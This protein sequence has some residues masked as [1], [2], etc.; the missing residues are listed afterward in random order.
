[1]ALH[2]LRNIVKHS[3]K[4]KNEYS[5]KKIIINSVHGSYLEAI[6]KEG[7]LAKALQ[8]RGHNIKIL[9]CGGSMNACTVLF[10][11]DVPPNKW[12]CRNCCY[13]SKIFFEIIDLPYATY[14]DYLSDKDI[15][16]IKNIVKQMSIE[17]YQKY[18]HKG[19][20]VGDHALKSVQR[21]FKGE[22]SKNGRYK[23][24]DI[25][26]IRLE[27]AIIATEVAEKIIKREEPDILVTSH[28][29]YSEFGSFSDYFSNNGKRVCIWGSGDKRDTLTFDLY[30]S[31]E[32]F[33]KIYEKIRKKSILNGHEE[34]KNFFN[35]RVKAKEG[36]VSLYGFSEVKKE[37]L[38]Q[39]FN[40]DNYDKTYI[41]FPNVPW[42]AGVMDA[43]TAFENVY[44]WLT[45]TIE[46]FQD[47]PKLQLIIKI[48]PSELRVMES[49]HTVLDYI[50]DHF[51]SLTENIKIIPPD[52]KISPYSLFPFIDVGIVYNG[53]VGLEMSTQGIPV[54]VTGDAHYGKKS[55]TFDITKK[56]EYSK[57]LFDEITLTQ[58]Q[59]DIAKVYANFYFIKNFVPLNFLYINNFL[60]IGWKINSLED[61]GPGK[62]KHLDHICDYIINGGIYQNW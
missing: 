38:E 23:Y 37:E 21:F 15:S 48:H 60:D 32:Y 1:M 61:L 5:G 22:E 2:R 52:T 45:F 58:T 11:N 14:F 53:T 56:D 33:K 55:F 54:V 25:L 39:Q 50:N 47:K 18:T 26:R 8:L 28:G 34:L 16:K 13:F 3:R 36:Q 29:C 44:D 20:K 35:K 40:F 7:G 24:D 49:K 46:L 10:T 9:L 30:K 31:D 57:V 42:D 6:Y 4:I 17:E 12:M 59:Q 62:D 43:K 51:T 27:N 41:M 19:V